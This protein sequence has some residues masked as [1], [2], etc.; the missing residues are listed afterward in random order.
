MRSNAGM[1]ESPRRFPPPWKVNGNDSCYWIEDAEGKRFCYTYFRENGPIG[2]Y[3]ES[4]LSRR[5][6]LMIVR[7]VAKLPGL[8][9]PSTT[10][11]PPPP[12]PE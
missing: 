8:L 3:R 10:R 6:A 4:Y 1:S 9:T 11:T 12:L 7:N 2:T 5:E